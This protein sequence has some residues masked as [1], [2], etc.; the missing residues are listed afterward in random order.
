[1]QVVAG[2]AD[3]DGGINERADGSS[4]EQSQQQQ[5]KRGREALYKKGQDSH[6]FIDATKDASRVSGDNV[7]LMLGDKKVY[8]HVADDK[9]VYLGGKN[10]EGTFARV[11]TEAGPSINVFAKVG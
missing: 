1:V 11:M 5:Q 8:V 4:G 2:A 3:G 7:H 10:G 9:K 6:R